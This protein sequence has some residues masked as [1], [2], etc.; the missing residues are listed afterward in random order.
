LPATPLYKRLEKAGRLTRPKHW[1][2][3]IPF[4]MA[5]TP[6]KMTIDEAHAEVKHGWDQAYSPEALAHAVESMKDQPLGYRL[7]IFIARLCFRGIYFPMMG[8]MAWVK[9]IAQNRRT[10]F[11][12]VRE[13][14][15]AGA[16]RGAT[17][18]IPSAPVPSAEAAEPIPQ[19]AEG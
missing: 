7:N 14:F 13:G 3:F 4:A 6:L 12:L 10:I 11:K 8:K 16:W 1:Q 19:G 18:R 2:E 9:V 5:H 15:K 17:A